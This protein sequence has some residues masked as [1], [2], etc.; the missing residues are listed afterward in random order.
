MASFIPSSPKYFRAVKILGKEHS[1]YWNSIL[2]F[3][4]QMGK[5]KP[6][7]SCRTEDFL[8]TYMS[9]SYL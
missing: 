6:T 9:H 8:R 1:L 5:K 7:F 4:Y 2:C 3:L